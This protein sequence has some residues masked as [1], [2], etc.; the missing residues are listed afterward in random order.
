ML[1]E[2]NCPKCGA[3]GLEAHQPDGV[4]VCS[5]CGNTFAADSSIACP[6]CETVNPPDAG[7]C[8]SCGKK[9]RSNCPACGAQNWAGA[10]FCAAC[11]HNI[12]IVSVM[13]ERRAQGF[14]GTLQQQRDS[15]NQLKQEDEIASQ[16]RLASMYEVEERR[17]AHLA[18]QRAEQ[19]RQQNLLLGAAIGL[20]VVFVIAV[21]VGWWL[22]SMAR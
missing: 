17:Q 14:R 1:K 10:D 9:L 13:A 16:K 20:I 5:F 3:P 18:R 7:F 8:K 15:A 21:G 22:L 19:T 12:D 6:H 2:L 11:G 4:V